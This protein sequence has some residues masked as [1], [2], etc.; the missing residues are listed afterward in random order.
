MNATGGLNGAARE[1]SEQL[2]RQLSRLARLDPTHPD[3]A[4]IQGDILRRFYPDEHDAP[5]LAHLEVAGQHLRCYRLAQ[6]LSLSVQSA[7]GYAEFQLGEAHPASPAI[8]RLM[9]ELND[10][11]AAS[12]GA[13]NTHVR[14]HRIGGH[15]PVQ[16]AATAA[17]PLPTLEL[18]WAAP[19]TQNRSLPVS[20]HGAQEQAATLS[21]YADADQRRRDAATTQ[22]TPRLTFS[23]AEVNR[24]AVRGMEGRTPS[25]QETTA[26]LAD[27]LALRGVGMGTQPIMTTP[28]VRELLRHSRGGMPLHP[29]EVQLCLIDLC[30]LHASMCEDHPAPALTAPAV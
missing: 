8:R 14:Q 26:L 3:S 18:Q 30:D 2:R 11:T 10:L 28:K 24:F 15:Q 21:P 13:V 12:S 6:T 20:T 16:S 22:I 23:Q 4:R 17:P 27:L 5:F 1:G 9:R 7:Q 19:D 25:V 29:E